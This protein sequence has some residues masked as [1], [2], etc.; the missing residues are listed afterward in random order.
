MTETFPSDP[1]ERDSDEA[2]FSAPELARDVGIT[3][4]ALRFYEAKGLLQPRR[5]GTRRAYDR[6]D[7][8]R[9]VLILRG[10]RLGFSL[11]SIREYLELYDADPG[12][13]PQLQLLHDKVSARIKALEMQR[14][15]LEETLVELKA[16]EQ[17]T[18]S[19]IA[20]RTSEATD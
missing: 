12:Q 19:T 17:Q 3:P 11:A 14:T 6:R 13:L 1:L 2:L 20:Q 9:L 7:R 4:R 5:V 15:A 10:K 18:A 8:A 16:I